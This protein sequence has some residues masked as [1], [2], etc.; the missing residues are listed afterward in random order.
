VSDQR[1]VLRISVAANIRRLRPED[2][3]SLVALRRQALEGDPLAFAASV[4]D[5]RGLS[6][7]FVRT[8]LA[9][10]HGQAVFGRFEGTHLAGMVGVV[11]ESK[12]KRRHVALIWGMYVAPPARRQGVGRALLAAAIAHARTWP[13]V[14]HVQLSV[15]DT[16]TSARRLYEAAGFRCWGRESRALQWEGRFVDEFHL[17]LDLGAPAGA[18]PSQGSQ[19]TG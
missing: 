7:E 13:A 3:E 12:L 4:D 6:L 1:S 15:T 8:A 9:D 18:P 11:R 5:D 17:V 14:D 10:D 19:R 16:A 2:A